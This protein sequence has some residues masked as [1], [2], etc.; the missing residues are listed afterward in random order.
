MYYPQDYYNFSLSK[1]IYLPILLIVIL[2]FSSC[3]P[4]RKQLSTSLTQ[5][6]QTV[7]QQAKEIAMLNSQIVNLNKEVDE[8]TME[9]Q[10]IYSA[11]HF[12]DNQ[13]TIAYGEQL[14][15]NGRLYT[16]FYFMD[17]EGDFV[18]EL[19]T[20]D[21]VTMFDKRGLARVEANR[22]AFLLT[23]DGTRYR[24]TTNLDDLEDVR[25]VNKFAALDLSGQKLNQLDA[26]IFDYPHL[27]CLL[28][29]SNRLTQ[30]PSAIQEL[31]NLEY[32]D[33]SRNK[34]ETVPAEIGTLK[35]LKLLLLNVNK[36]ENLP[37][38][39]GALTA[40]E[41][42]NI[43]RLTVKQLPPTIGKLRNLKELHAQQCQLETLPNEIGQLKKLRKLNLYLN[44]LSTL[45]KEIGELEALDMLS[46]ES[47]RLK[48]LPPTIG[49]LTQL[50]NLRINDNQLKA[51][52]IAI[53]QLDKLLFLS[54]S[55]NHLTTLPNTIGELEKLTSFSLWNNF[56]S[57]L[58]NEIGQLKLLSSLDLANNEF[59]ELPPSLLQLP[60]LLTL[61]LDNNP[62][63]ET[64]WEAIRSAL[65]NTTVGLE[66]VYRAAKA[67][68][69]FNA[70]FYEKAFSFQE[71][72]A[73]DNGNAVV[74]YTL[75][76]Y[77]LFAKKPLQAIE[78][79]KK[80]SAL[81]PSQI[82]VET[83]LALGHLLNNDWEQAKAIYLKHKGQAIPDDFRNRQWDEVFLKDIKELEAAGILHE[84]FEKVKQLLKE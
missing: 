54:A 34:L 49:N 56:L 6:N 31:K 46:L 81:D 21:K 2:I 35:Q 77:A 78:A 61:T 8:A 5:Q 41:K 23:T 52:P 3:T 48:A 27:K 66:E 16:R 67:R 68:K 73:A 1:R 9:L 74:W 59:T 22:E 11:F 75:S 62:I 24:V 33:L 13:Y 83:N 51:L 38:E 63:P 80:T 55:K 72:Q 44:R 47:N 53:G 36:I 84:D 28:L 37:A 19:G 43:S 30:I 7:E 18:P 57:E 69:Y 60:E 50:T 64:D 39:I 14:S 15:D 10:K 76:W 82:R 42:L 32:L 17:M 29:N 20:W 79:A 26:R 71:E 58:P 12:Y 25:I 65:P 45:P 4:T 40:L 70:G